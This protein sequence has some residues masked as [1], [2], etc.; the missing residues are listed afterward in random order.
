MSENTT[1]R[2][3]L[4]QRARYSTLYLWCQIWWFYWQIF[5]LQF[6]VKKLEAQWDEPVSL[7]F[8]SALRKLNTEPSIGASHQVLVRLAKQFQRRRFL[9]ID[10]LETRIAYS[11][12]VC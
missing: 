5:I 7:T 4:Q 9:E 1:W 2:Y 3:F 12:H 6:Y 8:H 11:S 10:Q